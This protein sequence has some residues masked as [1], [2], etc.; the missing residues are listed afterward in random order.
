MANAEYHRQ[1][2]RENREKVARY[3]LDFYHAHKSE[4]G[5]ADKL[6]AYQRHLRMTSWSAWL[7][8]KITTA[9][10]QDRKDGRENN[11]DK[12]FIM[13]LLTRQNYK[14]AVTGI[15]L[16]HT[17]DD[18]ASASIDR[19]DSSKGHTKENVQLVCKFYNMGKGNHSDFEA[20]AFIQK[21]S[22]RDSTTQTHLKAEA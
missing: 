3:K 8:S 1:W 5:R 12:S 4:P 13:D 9:R 17:P 7:G 14:C 15:P 10:S 11:L 21:M 22:K 18:L 19:I 6:R 2:R 20:R 16:T